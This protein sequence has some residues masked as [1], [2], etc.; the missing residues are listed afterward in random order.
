MNANDSAPKRKFLAPCPQRA[1]LFRALGLAAVL[2]AC[3]PAGAGA[4]TV[5]PSAF[6]N[7]I[8]I[9]FPGYT[10]SSTLTDFPVL[11]RLSAARNKFAYAKC[12]ANGADLRFADADGNL[13]SHEIDTWD[14][15]GESLVWVKVPSF[16]ETAVV[17]VYYGC[18]N[19]PAVDPADVWSN[20]YVGVWHLGDANNRTQANSTTNVLDFQCHDKEVQNVDL[21][22]SA[23]AVGGAVGFNKK[24]NNYGGLYLDDPDALLSGLENCTIEAWVYPTNNTTGTYILSNITNSFSGAYNVVLSG[25]KNPRML[26]QT[27]GKVKN[28]GSGDQFDYPGALQDA[29]PVNEWSHFAFARTGST[30]Y[31]HGYLDGTR[32]PQT[33]TSSAGQLLRTPGSSV[34]LGNLGG[35]LVDWS[36]SCYIYKTKSFL[37]NIDEVRVSDVVRSD[38][39]IKASY[40]CVTDP[41]F[42]GVQKGND[43]SQYS[44]RFSIAF[45][46]YSGSET[47]EDFPVLVKV[48]EGS[49]VGFSYADCQK[50]HGSDL[51]FAD[52]A[53]NLLASEVDT[54]DPNG[55]SLIWV[56]VPALTAAT[57]I[58]AYYG[59]DSAPV[60]D[61][62]GVWSNDYVGVWHMTENAL[63]LSE[64]SGVSTPFSHKQNNVR[65]GCEGVIGA[66]V[67][68]SGASSWFDVLRADDDDDLDGFTAFTLEMWTK[69]AEGTWS[70]SSN[71]G[72]MEK[73]PAKNT[74]TSG[75]SYYWYE[76]KDKAGAAGVLFYT[77]S[78]GT[79]K[80]G[81]GNAVK[82]EPGV[83]THQAFVRTTGS[84]R[85]YYSYVGGTNSWST[86]S[87]NDDPVTSSSSY[88]MV[89][90]SG[91]GGR[92]PG[93]I[94]EVRI[95][96][97][98]RSAD[99][100]KATHDTVAKADF[101]RYGKAQEIGKTTL[102]I[103][104]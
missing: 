72:M 62:T 100:I 82:P 60:V 22:V 55:V 36:S 93:Q 27:E 74:E 79:A 8:S 86:A 99:W 63:P 50:P 25:G 68:C 88:L 3:V 90:G 19:P 26:S 4:A 38:D 6:S 64:S 73:R 13:L 24:G 98:G 15:T 14:P 45:S 39:W 7:K 102:L 16:D 21:A 30:G 9:T 69:Q 44:H 65:L 43:W 59:W 78:A 52:A 42:T 71:Y 75:N 34:I 20:G 2:T 5:D 1:S 57:K 53:G 40:D 12:A 83:W 10:G 80:Y 61:S 70:T 96:R 54:W 89:G 103:F 87:G 56:K 95:S 92:F 85:R 77:G 49:P 94:D 51:R 47:L 32:D 58:S 91:S 33:K 41:A 17:T 35:S 29:C 46:S 23:G 28:G 48:S 67:D 11:V 76:N 31:I 37:G 101:A 66:A 104:R 81:T 97:A 84:N 18:A